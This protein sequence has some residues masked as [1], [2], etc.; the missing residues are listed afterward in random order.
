[1]SRRVRCD[2][3][4]ERPNEPKSMGV[5]ADGAANLCMSKRIFSPRGGLLA[6]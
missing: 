6:A 5:V 1:M 3:V 4:G 2:S